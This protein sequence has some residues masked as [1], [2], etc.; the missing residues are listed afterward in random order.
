MLSF[1]KTL[2]KNILY[3]WI[4]WRFIEIPMEIINGWRSIVKFYSYYF[5]IP[6]LLKT[7]FSPWRQNIWSYEGKFELTKYLETLTSNI[8]S[9]FIG[10]IMRLG[11]IIIGLL[12][13]FLASCLGIIILALWLIAPYILIVGL[14]FG[15]LIIF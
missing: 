5:S 14:I 4:V 8:A 6:L 1:S 9:R 3:K 2:E 13:E 10:F 11:L 15:I 12:A 7:L